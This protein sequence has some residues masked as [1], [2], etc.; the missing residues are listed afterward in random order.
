MNLSAMVVT[1]MQLTYVRRLY[2]DGADKTCK[3]RIY[4]Y[5]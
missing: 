1:I 4:E 3:L 2:V 5:V